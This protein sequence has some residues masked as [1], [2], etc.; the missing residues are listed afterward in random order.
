VYPCIHFY[1]TGDMPAV[2]S[3]VAHTRQVFLLNTIYRCYLA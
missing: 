1:S 3:S 2:R